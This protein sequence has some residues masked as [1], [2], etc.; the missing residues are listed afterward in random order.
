MNNELFDEMRL[1]MEEVLDLVVE[2]LE[3]IKTGVA[4]P[5]LIENVQIEAYPGQKLTLRE[6]ANILVPDP[7]M[8]VV[9]PWDESVIEK[10]E[11]ELAE[12]ELNLSPVVDK[13]M[14]RIAIPPLTEE[15]REEL[16]KLVGQRVESGKQ[17]IRDVR[18]KKKNEIEEMKNQEGVS[19]DDVF[20]WFDELQEITN[21][22]VGK[23]ETIGQRKEVE[24]RQI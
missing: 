18:H 10:I 4:K 9:Q 21:E 14:I 12:S 16:V 17:M 13:N 7:H 22:Y 1:R 20:G 6:L 2:D 24:L 11:K 8:L 3:M 15:R 23:L 5:S 19:E